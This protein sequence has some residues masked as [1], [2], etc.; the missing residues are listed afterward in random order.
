MVV[1]DFAAVVAVVFVSVLVVLVFVVGVVVVVVVV[2]GLALVL[3]FFIAAL[4]LFRCW[5]LSASFFLD[6]L[7][8][9]DLWF[10]FI[11]IVAVLTLMAFCFIGPAFDLDL[12]GAFLRW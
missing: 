4:L 9:L 3:V 11:F 6:C 1:A 8:F 5:V 10:F 2:V 12:C 7:Q